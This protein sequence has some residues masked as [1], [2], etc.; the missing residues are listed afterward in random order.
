MQAPG[1]LKRR[2]L[3]AEGVVGSRWT[4]SLKPAGFIRPS[5][6]KGGATSLRCTFCS[7]ACCAKR[8]L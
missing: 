2:S 6:P 5:G 3:H 8:N 7:A 1:I 4:T